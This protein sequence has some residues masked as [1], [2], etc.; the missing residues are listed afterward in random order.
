VSGKPREF[1]SD[2]RFFFGGLRWRLTKMTGR[3]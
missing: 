1:S 2:W 3:V